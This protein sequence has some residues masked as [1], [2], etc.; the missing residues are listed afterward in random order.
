VWEAHRFSCPKR[1]TIGAFLLGTL[2]DDWRDYVA[3]H[4]KQLGCRFCVANLDDMEGQV[5]AAEQ[6]RLQRRIF[7]STVGFLKA[8]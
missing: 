6:Q 8:P 4:L 1:S 3:F 2:S 7:E 5:A